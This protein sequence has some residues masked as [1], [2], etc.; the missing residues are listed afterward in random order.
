M[1]DFRQDFSQDCQQRVTLARI[2]CRVA[3][4]IFFSVALSIAEMSAFRIV[5]RMAGFVFEACGQD[6]QNSRR[7]KASA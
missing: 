6:G 5:V 1:T 4:R 2:A 3:A 7:E